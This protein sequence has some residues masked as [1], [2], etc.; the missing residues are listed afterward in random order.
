MPVSK[1]KT[2][3]M[4]RLEDTFVERTSFIAQLTVHTDNW[5]PHYIVLACSLHCYFSIALHWTTNAES[6]HEVSRCWPTLLGIVSLLGKSWISLSRACAFH[7]SGASLSATFISMQSCSYL[8]SVK[9]IV[10]E[11]LFLQDDYCFLIVF[12]VLAHS[13]SMSSSLSGLAKPATS[14]FVLLAFS[15]IFCAKLVWLNDWIN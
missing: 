10:G 6:G 15:S 2:K 7:R 1:L 8:L 11:L 4:H 12:Y 5:Q 13:E 14:Y 3:L 9:G